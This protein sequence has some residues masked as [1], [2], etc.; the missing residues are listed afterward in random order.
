LRIYGFNGG[1]TQLIRT[2]TDSSAGCTKR[3]DTNAEQVHVGS[4][5]TD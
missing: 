2:E 3:W 1:Y 5:T 4:T